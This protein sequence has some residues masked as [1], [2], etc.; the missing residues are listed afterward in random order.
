MESL[1]VIQN[2]NSIGK[3]TK[4]KTL[5]TS[6][7]VAD[8]LVKYKQLLDSGVISESE[9]AGIKRKLLG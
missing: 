7:S 5:S 8:E 9:F 2:C 1:I 4:S 6:G 3:T